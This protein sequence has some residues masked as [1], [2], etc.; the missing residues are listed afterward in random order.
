[1]KLKWI[2]FCGYVNVPFAS[3]GYLK[4]SAKNIEIH[5]KSKLMA[6]GADNKKHPSGSGAGSGGNIVLDCSMLSVIDVNHNNNKNA[7]FN[8]Q[9]GNDTENVPQSENNAIES[10]APLNGTVGRILICKHKLFINGNEV[11]TETDGEQFLNGV[12]NPKIFNYL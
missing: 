1:M 7:I 5:S 8:C 9:G 12:S 11:E 10:E 6:I 2:V 4:L 3:G